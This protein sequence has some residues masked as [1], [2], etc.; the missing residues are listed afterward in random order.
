MLVTPDVDITENSKVLATLQSDP[1]G[2]AVIL[3]VDRDTVAGTFTV[4]LSSTAP[5]ECQVAWFVIS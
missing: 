3:R 4:H 1:E 2:R 5:K